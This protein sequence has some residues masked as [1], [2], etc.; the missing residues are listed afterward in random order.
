ILTLS[1]V[2]HIKNNISFVDNINVYPNPTDNF[3]KIELNAKKTS[4]FNITLISI[5]GK[6]LTAKEY[7]NTSNIND[8]FD[9]RNYST[10][11]YLLQI[12]SENEQASYQIIKH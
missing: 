1:I 9:L 12:E 8:A 4:S 5:D 2:T 6:V 3:I 7:K 11:V 10:G